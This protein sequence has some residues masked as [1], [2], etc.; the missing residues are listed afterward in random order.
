MVSV[1]CFVL[2]FSVGVE[3]NSAYRSA[4]APRV[5][6]GQTQNASDRTVSRRGRGLRKRRRALRDPSAF[7]EAAPHTSK[8]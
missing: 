4:T 2:V 5:E 8:I 1:F 7:A 3:R 6:A